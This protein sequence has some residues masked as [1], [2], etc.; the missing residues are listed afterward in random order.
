MQQ[1]ISA[2]LDTMNTHVL[3]Q[4]LGT[5]ITERQNRQN[6]C[7]KDMPYSRTS[8][9]SVRFTFVLWLIISCSLFTYANANLWPISQTLSM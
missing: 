1:L 5:L 3:E 7:V 9:K 2:T 4:K 6:I 8:V